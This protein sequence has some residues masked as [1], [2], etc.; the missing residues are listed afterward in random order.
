MKYITAHFF[1]IVRPQGGPTVS[2]V[3]SQIQTMSIDARMRQC[4]NQKIRLEEVRDDVTNGI[5]L[6]LLKFTRIRDDNW[7]GV[8]ATSQEAKDLELDEDQ[9]L[10]EETFAAYC[11]STDRLV[12]QYSHFGVRAPKIREYLNAIHGKLNFHYSFSPVLT[13]ESFQKYER[14]KIVTSMAVTIEGVSDADLALM[15]GAG[16]HA[17]LKES[18]DAKA[19]S[20]TFSVNVDARMKK[21]KMERGWVE[22][23][24]QAVKERGGENDKLGIGAKENEEDTVEIIDL[25]EAR[26]VARYDAAEIGR[27]AGRRFDPD[28]MHALMGQTMR[29]WL[30][31]GAN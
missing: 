1:H 9:H 28:Q 15:E 22:K 24:V 13:D 10:S 27:T 30:A 14:K 26:K 17:A 18:I 11:P 31:A 23:I 7:P 8:V 16:I 20:F 25:L 12:V 2:D 4:G 6:R 19:T 5:P 29:E 3:L 21:N